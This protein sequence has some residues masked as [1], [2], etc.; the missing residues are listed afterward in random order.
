MNWPIDFQYTSH[1]DKL[2]NSNLLRFFL[3]L[4]LI[5]GNELI[6]NLI[7]ICLMQ[8]ISITKLHFVLTLFSKKNEEKLAPRKMQFLYYLIKIL[9]ILSY[10][11]ILWNLKLIQTS[12]SHLNKVNSSSILFKVHIFWESHKILRNLPLTFDC[13][14][15]SQK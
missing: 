4:S 2:C 5:V 8:W 11:Y 3:L 7:A 13:M 6:Y 14:Y 1:S 15:C 10:P 9:K 12:K